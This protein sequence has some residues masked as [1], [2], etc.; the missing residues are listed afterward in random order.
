VSLRTALFGKAKPVKP[1]L[2]YLLAVS[3]SFDV[4]RDELQLVS[5]GVAGICFKSLTTDGVVHTDEEL[6]AMLKINPTAL[7][8]DELGFK[9]IVEGNTDPD[10]LVTQ[11]H[12]SASVLDENGIGSNMLCAVFA[13]KPLN[14]PGQGTLRMVYL[15]KR[16]TYYPFSPTGEDTR[17][18]EFELRVQSFLGGALPLEQDLSKWMPLWGLPVN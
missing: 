12:K 18:N 5:S 1:N 9:W 14:P 17:D 10:A 7:S 2:E 4:L 15:F 16:G 13:F 8:T 6:V 11:L 3:K